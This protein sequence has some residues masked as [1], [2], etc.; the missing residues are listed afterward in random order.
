MF[1]QNKDT[2]SKIDKKCEVAISKKDS[3]QRQNCMDTTQKSDAMKVTR[4]YVMDR[5]IINTAS[6]TCISMMI[7]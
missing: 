4:T 7:Y 5:N 1:R 6:L 2:K 3:G